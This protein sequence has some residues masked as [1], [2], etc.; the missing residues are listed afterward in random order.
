MFPV[1][2][3]G[4]KYNTMKPIKRYVSKFKEEGEEDK[5]IK[6]IKDLIDLDWGKDEDAQNTA[7]ALFKALVYA[8][9]TSADK[10]I[11]DVS[12]FTS[13]MNIEDYK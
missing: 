6:A 10:F 11:Q 4:Q 12:D 2:K 1:R 9:T 3:E 8:D 7:I 13:K 5:S